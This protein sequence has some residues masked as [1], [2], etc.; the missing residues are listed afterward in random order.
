MVRNSN[1]LALDVFLPGATFNIMKSKE[2]SAIETS[3]KLYITEHL[4]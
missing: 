4:S 1:N 3:E 2:G